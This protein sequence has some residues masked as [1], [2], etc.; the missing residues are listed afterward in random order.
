MTA[1][2]AGCLA[3]GHVGISGRSEPTCT[4]RWSRCSRLTAHAAASP[5]F[6]TDAPVVRA[7][8]EHQGGLMAVE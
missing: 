8:I 3:V 6:S 5:I 4:M 2:Q 7:G 1:S